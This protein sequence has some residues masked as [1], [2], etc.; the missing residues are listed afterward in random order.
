[1]KMKRRDFL[2]GAIVTTAA[3]TFDQ[4]PFLSR[5]F[6]MVSPAELAADPRRPQFH[7][8]PAANWMN[9]PNGPIYLNGHYH[10]FY[11]YNPGGPIWGD[12][13]WGHA[14]SE[15]MVHWA[16]LPVALSPTRGGPDADGCFS[17]TIVVRNGV[18]TAIYTGVVSAP[19][20]QATIRDGIHSLRETQCLATSNDPQLRTWSKLR[21]PVIAAPPPVMHV[22]GFRDPSPW[23]QGDWWYMCVGSG[24]EHKGGA[25]LLYR[26]KDL[27]HWDYL[28]VIANGEG[29]GSSTSNPVDSGDMWECPDLF[30]LGGKH[31]LIYSTKGKV[32]WQSGKLD[33]KELTFHPD[34]RGVLDYGSFYAP[35]TQ[36]DKFGNRI[37]WGWVPETRPV[38]EYRAAGWAGMMSLP[39]VLTLSHDGRLSMGAA[40]AIEVLR[41]KQQT[42]KITADEE[43][44]RREIS[45]IRVEGCCSEI[46]C[47]ARR[48]A[49]PFGLSLVS[50][51][52][53]GSERQWIALRYDPTAADQISIDDKTVPIA[54]GSQG[55][56]EF[57]MYID[58]SVIEVFIN[59]QAAYTKRFYYPGKR[60]PEMRVSISGKTTN[61]SSL[62]IWQLSPISPNRLTT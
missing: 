43:R 19:E 51:E 11:Q 26:S 41:K 55:E 2:A 49:D 29:D 62:S 47:N 50:L 58:G 30:P 48:S 57:Y 4:D 3:I 9:D 27:R 13:H 38:E 42:F 31:V 39:R 45:A 15:D 14:I 34:Q 6:A 18:V 56:F 46:L 16:H 10:M 21:T 12:M 28:H 23:R 35:K 5:V 52:D 25:V 7:L 1:M 60:Q 53:G 20:N 59:R 32:Y 8:L 44:T 40:P 36:V 17:G 33:A 54:F 22:T 61:L 37:L 24:I